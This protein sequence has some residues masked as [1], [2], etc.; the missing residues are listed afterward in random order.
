MRNS[1]F[2]AELSDEEIASPHFRRRFLFVPVVTSKKAQADTVI[3][4]VPP[5]SDLGFA[6][7]E[8]YQQ[9]ILKEVERPKLLPSKVVELMHKEGFVRFNLHHHTRLWKH[10]DGKNPGKGYGVLIAN[11]WYW[12]EGWV[13]EVR[14]HCSQ[15]KDSYSVIPEQ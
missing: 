13:N 7:N 11:T 2:D 14:K 12:Y 4:F 9:V 5:K 10:L 15:N 3:E 6:I 8:K 1:E